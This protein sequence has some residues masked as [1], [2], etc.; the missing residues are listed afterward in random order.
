MKTSQYILISFFGFLITAMLVLY[1]DSLKA[2]NDNQ[3]IMAEYK[4]IPPVDLEPFSTIVSGAHANIRIEQDSAYS[5]GLGFTMDGV[6]PQLAAYRVAN[7]TLFILESDRSVRSQTLIRCKSLHSIV[8]ERESSVSL[9]SFKTDSLHIS[10]NE[11]Q[12]SGAIKKM[13]I[14]ILDLHIN[15]ESRLYLDLE[16]SRIN[17]GI[18]RGSNSDINLRGGQTFQTLDIELKD[19]SVLSLSGLVDELIMQSDTTSSYTIRN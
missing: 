9:R 19:N 5:L 17:S 12:L 18:L 6:I 4:N 10:L 11:S 15:N 1:V 2:Y 16:Q 7:D 8:G 3:A 14:K 13:D